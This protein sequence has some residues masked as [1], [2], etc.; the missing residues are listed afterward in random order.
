M[1]WFW[2]PNDSLEG[3]LGEADTSAIALSFS[4]YQTVLC[5][6]LKQQGLLFWHHNSS[7]V[8]QQHN[9]RVV[10]SEGIDVIY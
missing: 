9:L 10:F 1:K 3:Y 8:A 5:P 6:V 4:P 7:K 2:V